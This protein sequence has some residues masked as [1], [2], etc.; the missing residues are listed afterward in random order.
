MGVGGG[1]DLALMI[2]QE[3]A[4]CDGKDQG[5]GIISSGR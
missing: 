4:V 3:C 1:G 5:D 2:V